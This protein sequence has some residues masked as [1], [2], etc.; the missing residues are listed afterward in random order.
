[1]TAWVDL[2][3]HSSCSDG[4]E[5]PEKLVA[6]A[7]GVEVSA[8]AL[9]DHDTVEGVCAAQQAAKSVGLAFLTGVEISCSFDGR[10]IHVVGLG[11]HTESPELKTLLESLA[12]MRRNRVDTI[13]RLLHNRGIVC[14]TPDGQTGSMGRM[15]VAVA[16]Y[17]MG[18]ASSV[19]NA[20]DR[21]LNRGC[22]AYV[23]K[24]LPDVAQVVDVI[25]AS[26][27]LA[28]I[29]HP[30]LGHWIIKQLPRLLLQPFDGLEAWHPSHDKFLTNDIIALAESHKLLLSGGSDCHGNVKGDGV[31]LGRIRTPLSC[32]ERIREVL[33]I[34]TSG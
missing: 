25:H 33:C 22:P 21:Y 31:N 14:E 3:L 28:F 18:K 19:Q 27:G 29:A 1:M 7:A 24:Q 26:N 16:L 9:T 15:H 12:A 6:R 20:F 13:V 11:I 17:E 23:P 2:H 34:E 32:F 4:T 30:G 10:E 8:I 5:T